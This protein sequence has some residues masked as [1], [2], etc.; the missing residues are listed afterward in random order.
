MCMRVEAYVDAVF[1]RRAA[2]QFLR[3][4]DARSAVANDV[5]LLPDP[6]RAA[7]VELV[8][9]PQTSGC[10]LR[11]YEAVAPPGPLVGGPDR[12]A[13]LAALDRLNEQGVITR[14]GGL[15]PSPYGPEARDDLR[16]IAT[17]AGPGYSQQVA[18]LQEIVR[19]SLGDRPKQ[20]NT[21]MA[22]DLAI[23]AADDVFDLAVLVSGDSDL[24][25]AI[26]H[27]AAPRPG[28]RP[29]RSITLATLPFTKPGKRGRQTL[30]APALRRA[31]R[32][33]GSL[34]I[35]TEEAFRCMFELSQSSS[36]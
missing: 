11:W 33:H 9:A 32:E 22:I 10:K 27:V 8:E 24:V 6:M 19:L 29:G 17:A 21:L 25:P 16:T 28:V 26:T 34:T 35:V 2:A 23:R 20:I 7:L 3:L 1:F 13:Q 18:R 4:R 30:V 12:N 5:R 14:A 15:S 36:A 31:A